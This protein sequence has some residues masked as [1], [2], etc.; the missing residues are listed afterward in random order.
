M[1]LF[2]HT[3]YADSCISLKRKKITKGDS[4]IVYYIFFVCLIV[5]EN[6][7]AEDVEANNT[8]VEPKGH[9]A[10]PKKGQKIKPWSEANNTRVEP[11][12]HRAEPK[13]GQKIKPWSEEEIAAIKRS[14]QGYIF[15][16][17]CPGKTPCLEAIAKEPALKNRDWHTVKFKAAYIIS[18]KK[19]AIK[20]PKRK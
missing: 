1:L 7:E 2:K 12:G 18:K 13:K 15:S 3:H 6:A 8:R 20:K 14:L 19:A 17:T 11:K 5:L 10:E 9:R 16:L 4:W